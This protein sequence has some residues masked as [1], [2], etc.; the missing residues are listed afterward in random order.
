[1]WTDS[2]MMCLQ[3]G[4]IW[5]LVEILHSLSPFRQS[6]AP[7]QLEQQVVRRPTDLSHLHTHLYYHVIAQLKKNGCGCEQLLSVY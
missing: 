2:Q 5:R 6:G 1:M 4:G 3:A 7:L